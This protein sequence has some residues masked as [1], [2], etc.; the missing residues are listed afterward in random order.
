MENY[1]QKWITKLCNYQFILP[2]TYIIQT[3]TYEG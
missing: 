2:A 3:E 1:T